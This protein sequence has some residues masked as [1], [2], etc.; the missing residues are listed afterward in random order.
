MRKSK[1]IARSLERPRKICYNEYRDREVLKLKGIIL[2]GGSGTRLY[3]L[4]KSVSKQLQSIYDKPM[5]YYPLSVLMLAGIQDILIITTPYDQKSFQKQLGT[6]EDF[7]ITLHYAI[8][9]EP[10]GL[11]QAFTI[12]E[13]FIGDDACAMVLGDNIF[14]GNGFVEMLQ[15]A[16]RNAEEGKA[17]NFGYEVHDPNRFGIMELDE[18]KNILSVEEKPL[19]PKSNFAITGLY[20]YPSGVSQK[21]HLVKPSPRGEL[22]ITTLNDFYLQE[23]NLKAELL[24]GGFSWFDAGT[25][26]SKLEAEN[27]IYSVQKNRGK[28]IACLEQIAFDKGWIDLESLRKSAELMKKNSYG[29]YLQKVVEKNLIKK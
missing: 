17:T 4:T 21:A 10:K 11:A 13:E 12:G 20:F 1:K 28:V 2:A 27:F 26:E 25:F 3:P 29:Q 8:Q 9:E 23:N 22:E 6:G 15:N 7:G 14:Y 18:N 19:H 5:I 16:K 24:G